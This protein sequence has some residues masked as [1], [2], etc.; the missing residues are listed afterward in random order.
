MLS[1]SRHE[2]QLKTIGLIR[3]GLRRDPFCEFSCVIRAAI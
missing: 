1:D 2:Q 3:S